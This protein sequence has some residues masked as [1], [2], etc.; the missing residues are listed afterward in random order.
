MTDNRKIR[1]FLFF[2]LI[3]LFLNLP[4]IE[5]KEILENAPATT[6]HKENSIFREDAYLFSRDYIRD[7]DI[8]NRIYRGDKIVEIRNISPIQEIPVVTKSKKFKLSGSFS[9]TFTTH[10][11]KADTSKKAQ[12][13]SIDAYNT[14][15]VD[16]GS[17]NLPKKLAK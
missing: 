17:P 14:F 16:K 5:A 13:R 12:D 2:F 3:Y 4:D 11:K 6:L 8:Q 7:Y 1:Y 15:G 9:T 10:L